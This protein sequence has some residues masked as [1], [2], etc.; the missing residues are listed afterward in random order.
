MSLPGIP[1]AVAGTD[2]GPSVALS[3]A[4]AARGLG[5]A[6]GT[7]RS[8]E[9]RYGLAPSLHTPG[10]HRRYDPI[11]LARLGVMHRLVQEGVPPAEAARAAINTHIGA[12]AVDAAN[13][14]SAL[15]GSAG[16][17]GPHAPARDAADDPGPVAAAGAAPGAALARRW[18]GAP[19]APQPPIGAGTGPRR[20]VPGLP[21]LPAHRD[22][23]TGRS[24][25]RRDLGR[26]DPPGPGRHRGPLGGDQPRGGDRALVLHGGRRG[27]GRPL[28]PPGAAP[29]RSPG[30]PCQRTRGASRPPPRW[31]SRPPCPMSGSAAT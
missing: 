18:S 3:V 11:D 10:G 13:P 1:D 17:E 29:Q 9:R 20:D 4:G 16:A 31:C 15:L 6:P 24:G 7:L 14:Y 28:R 23:V 8:W 27:A 21:C 12:E 19:H 5:V 25:R 22:R 30:R 26:P 2:R